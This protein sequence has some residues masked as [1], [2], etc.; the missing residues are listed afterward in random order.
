MRET[1]LQL[2]HEGTREELRR[3]NFFVRDH[4]TVKAHYVINITV[5]LAPSMKLLVAVF[6]S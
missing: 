1:L 4:G 6:L 3:V 5:R 2:S